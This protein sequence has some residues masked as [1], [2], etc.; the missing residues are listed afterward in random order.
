MK[1]SIFTDLFLKV[2]GNFNKG[3]IIIKSC[4]NLISGNETFEDKKNIIH[5]AKSN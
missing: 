2:H 1:K 5:I 4:Q 3:E